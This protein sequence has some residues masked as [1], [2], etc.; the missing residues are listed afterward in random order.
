MAEQWVPELTM[1]SER[2][3]RLNKGPG[4]KNVGFWCLPRARQL[5]LKSPREEKW[6]WNTY[7]KLKY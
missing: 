2:Y 7:T 4:D 3:K 5:T 1:V 6:N